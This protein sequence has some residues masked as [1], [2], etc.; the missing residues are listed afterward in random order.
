MQQ[1]AL[2]EVCIPTDVQYMQFGREI[3]DLGDNLRHLDKLLDRIRNQH[4]VPQSRLVVSGN[5][6][7][8]SGYQHNH[9]TEALPS[10]TGDFHKTLC[11][12]QRFLGDNSRFRRDR[13]GFVDNVR[14]WIGGLEKDVESLRVRVRSHSMKVRWILA[15]GV[16]KNTDKGQDPFSYR[17]CETVS[18]MQSLLYR[19]V[20]AD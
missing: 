6:S 17:T 13:A 16:K 12:C 19:K 15:G 2:T 4:Q 18:E 10:I 20:S 9:E 11:E 5:S 1:Q 14:W 7:S 8:L 3:N